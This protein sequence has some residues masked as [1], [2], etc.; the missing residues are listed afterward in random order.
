MYN[1]S[2]EWCIY[3]HTSVDM[4]VTVYVDVIFVRY[5]DA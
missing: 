2:E 3:R 1:E 4:Y 5:I